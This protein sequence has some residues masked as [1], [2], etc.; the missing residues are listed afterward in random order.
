[1]KIVIETIENLT[2]DEI[3]IRCKKPTKAIQRIYQM[4]ADEMSLT[5][6]LVFYKENEEYYFPLQ[7][8]LF[9]E[10]SGDNV[11]AH[12]ADDAFRIKF[13]LYELEEMLPRYFVRVA[14]STIINIKHV[15]SI[16]RNLTS[17][18]LVQFRDSHKKVYVSRLYYQTLA[19]KLNERR[20]YYE[21]E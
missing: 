4:I 2:D 18:S 1:M 14:K 12:T 11:Y 13:R 3:I 8:V 16:N 10:T 7:D 15:L 19:Q 21:D 9:F 6:N 17:S 5:P 20:H